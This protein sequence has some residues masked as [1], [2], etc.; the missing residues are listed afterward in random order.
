MLRLTTKAHASTWFFRICIFFSTAYFC[1]SGKTYGAFV[2]DLVFTWLR[3]AI[4]IRV[5]LIGIAGK[6]VSSSGE[7]GVNIK[8]PLGD[9][10]DF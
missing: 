9:E 7:I 10:R 5:Y 8:I 4:Y 3:I 1:I 2:L 6:G